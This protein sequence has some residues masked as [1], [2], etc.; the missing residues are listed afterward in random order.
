MTKKIFR[1]IFGVTLAALAI[2]FGLTLGVLYNYF[3]SVQKD[4]L[5][6]QLL[7]AS[8]AVEQNKEAYLEKLDPKDFRLT[9]VDQ[10]GTVLFDTQYD[11]KE[12]ENHAEREEIREAMEVET[13]SVPAIPK[14]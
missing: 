12:M 4:A 5:K 6:S 14:H 2:C 1:S 10:D 3:G 8:T 9:W 7:M 11:A 13:E